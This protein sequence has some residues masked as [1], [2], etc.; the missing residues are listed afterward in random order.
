MW[1][2]KLVSWCK[3]AH[4]HFEGLDAMNRLWIHLTPACSFLFYKSLHIFG[5]TPSA[6]TFLQDRFMMYTMSTFSVWQTFAWDHFTSTVGNV[7]GW[8]VLCLCDSETSLS[9]FHITLL[10]PLLFSCLLSLSTC[11][12][13]LSK[14]SLDLKLLSDGAGGKFILWVSCVRS[15]ELVPVHPNHIQ[16]PCVTI[17]YLK[18]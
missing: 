18:K 14:V 12:W 10:S 3:G 15:G 17:D 13:N 5:H 1:Y 8:R 6:V 7:R 16:F 9:S 2:N 11:Q 4:L